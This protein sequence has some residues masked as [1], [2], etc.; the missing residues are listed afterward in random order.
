MVVTNGG[1]RQTRNSAKPKPMQFT[2][3]GGHLLRANP[4]T[5]EVLERASPFRGVAEVLERASGS[6]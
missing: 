1:V 4:G 3:R 6:G 2:N 5:A